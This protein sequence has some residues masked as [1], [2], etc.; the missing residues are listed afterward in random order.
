MRLYREIDER[1][2]Y[3]PRAE[4]TGHDD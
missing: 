3:V 1:A 4:G 2:V